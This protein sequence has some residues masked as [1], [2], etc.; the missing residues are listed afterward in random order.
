DRYGGPGRVSALGRHRFAGGGVADDEARLHRHL[1][2]LSQLSDPVARLDREG[3]LA[4]YAADPLA[5]PFAPVPGALRRDPAAGAAL[6]AGAA[7][8]GGL[9]PPDAAHS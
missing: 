3:A 9:P 1:R 6:G 8:C 7:A 4:G 5:A 2:P